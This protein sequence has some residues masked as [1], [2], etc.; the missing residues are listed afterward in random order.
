MCTQ[1]HTYICI[2]RYRYIGFSG[3]SDGKEYT[4]NVRDLGSIPGLGRSPGGWCGNAVQYY[5]LENP[6]DRGTWQAIVHVVTKHWTGLN[7]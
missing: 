1:T 4:C 6:M 3:G 7:N 5:Y 2:Y